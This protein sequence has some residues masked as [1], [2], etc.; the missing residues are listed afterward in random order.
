[1]RSCAKLV[2]VSSIRLALDGEFD[3][4]SRM[5]PRSAVAPALESRRSEVAEWAHKVVSVPFAPPQ[6]E[7]VAVSKARHGVRPI[8]IW[9]LPSRLLYRALSARLGPALEPER[10]AAFTWSEFE[11]SPL[12][13]PGRYI[14]AADI[15]SCYELIDHAL[16]AQE[17]IIQ[18]GNDEVVNAIIS[19]LQE[20]SGRRYGLPQQSAASDILAGAFL[21]KL[22]RALLRHGLTVA[23]YN[24]DFRINCQSWSDVVRNI[25][26]LSDEV[27][28]HGLILNDSKMFTWSR[29]AYNASVEEAESLRNEIAEAAQLDL[30]S[31]NVD[32]YDGDADM[33]ID[34]D[35]VELLTSEYILERWSVVAGRGHV[36]DSRRT[37]HRALLQLLPF[38]FTA[39]GATSGGYSNGLSIA[40]QMLR[41]EQTMTPHVA[42]YLFTRTDEHDVLT[43]FDKLL[44]QNAYLTGWQAWWLQ[45]P[46]SRLPN[47]TSGRGANKR[48]EWLREV[49]AGAER[50]P[51]LAAHAAMTLARHGLI[52]AESLLPMYDRSSPVT[53]PVVVAAIGL[54]NPPSRIRRAVTGDSQ[55]DQWVFQWASENA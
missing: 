21:D 52:D 41:Y 45:Q 22:E 53:R 44:R 55:L 26:I 24:D 46:L 6:Q 12:R 10:S 33:E 37:E 25:E 43:A 28:Q 31:Y 15:A 47:L 7:V 5:L 20:I 40:M 35:D 29:S 19:L 36:K 8:A 11:R 32:D 18:S 3:A 27:R 39:L 16:L 42:R 51:I 34:A 30:A 54:L 50:S 49:Y 13:E 2:H 9:D 4:A 38:A 17:L 14:I 23:R 1:M 48:I